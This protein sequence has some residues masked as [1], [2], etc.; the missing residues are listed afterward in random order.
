MDRGTVCAIDVA[1]AAAAVVAAAIVAVVAVGGGP[2]SAIV[3]LRGRATALLS[4][5]NGFGHV[6]AVQLSK[7]VKQVERGK[8]RPTNNSFYLDRYSTSIASA[9]VPQ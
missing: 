6:T 2:L 9:G 7:A 3:A 5:R 8:C 1:A 4:P